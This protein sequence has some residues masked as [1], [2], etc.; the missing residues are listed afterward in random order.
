MGAKT[1]WKKDDKPHKV[2]PSIRQLLRVAFVGMKQLQNNGHGLAGLQ[3]T[4]LLEVVHVTVPV[5]RRWQ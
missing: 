1:Q 3:W 5:V 4:F 2:I